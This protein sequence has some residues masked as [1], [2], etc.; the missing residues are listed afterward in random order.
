MSVQSILVVCTGNICRSPMAAALLQ[1]AHPDKDIDSAGI[2]AMV[3][4]PTDPRVIRS[5]QAIE[6]EAPEHLGQQLEGAHVRQA[7]LILVMTQEQAAYI[8]RHWS[9]SRGK[10]FRMGHWR[11]QDVP[12]PYR[13]SES[14]FIY[15]RQ[16]LQCCLEDWHDM[17]KE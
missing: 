7:D 9:F 5:L 1:H 11:H 4:Q 12:D 2:A 6:I 13:Q 8:G 10:V 16:L 14:A 3:G 17:L 15:T